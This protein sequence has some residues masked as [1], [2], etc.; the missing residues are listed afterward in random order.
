MKTSIEIDLS[1]INEEGAIDEGVKNYIIERISENLSSKC[2]KEITE[3]ARTQIATKLDQK[4]TELFDS[5]ME[6]GFIE[7]N[8]W[9][10]PIGKRQTVRELM[11]EKLDNA[12]TQPV[13]ER[14]GEPCNYD[15]IPRLTYLLNKRIN[16]LLD[17]R[18]GR[19]MK[20]VQKMME[21]KLGNTLAQTLA[22]KLLKALDIEGIVKEAFAK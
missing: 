20:D 3:A 19:I 14:T 6:E 1:W 7:R 18:Y 10:D 15:G 17:D 8:R 16:D 4:A 9:G 21:T 2:V 11:Q 22:T 12:L 5:F 13:N